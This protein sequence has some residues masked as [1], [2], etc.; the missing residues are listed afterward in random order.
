MDYHYNRAVSRS[1]QTV[2]WVDIY[3]MAYLPMKWQEL[4][5]SSFYFDHDEGMLYC[6]ICLYAD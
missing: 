2:A 5:V 4:D 6:V 1:L 3:S